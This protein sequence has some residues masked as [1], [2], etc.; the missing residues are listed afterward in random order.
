MKP[1]CLFITAARNINLR[2]NFFY[3]YPNAFFINQR[4]AKIC[5]TKET[6][7]LIGSFECSNLREKNIEFCTA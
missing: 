3:Y 7:L 1:N 2:L 6:T 4:I 5:P